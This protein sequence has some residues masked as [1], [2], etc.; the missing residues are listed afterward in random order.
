[1][2]GVTSFLCPN[3]YKASNIYNQI[4]LSDKKGQE[5]QKEPEVDNLGVPTF[6]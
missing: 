2:T 3:S 1:M 4:N 5:A 6:V